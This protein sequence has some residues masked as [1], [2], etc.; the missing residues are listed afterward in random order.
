MPPTSGPVPPMCAAGQGW[1]LRSVLA[2]RCLLKSHRAW[3]RSRTTTGEQPGQPDG[4]G[5]LGIS[6]GP[7]GG[8]PPARASRM[9]RTSGI[10]EGRMTYRRMPSAAAPSRSLVAISSTVPIQAK[11]EWRRSST[12][13]P[14]DE[15]D[16]VP[17]R[18]SRIVGDDHHLHE[19]LEL[20]T[21]V[22]WPLADL[23]V[24]TVRRTRVGSSRPVTVR[25]SAEA[26][27]EAGDPDDVGL[28][29]PAKRSTRP[30][31]PPTRAARDPEPA[32][33]RSGR[34][35]RRESTRRSTRSSHR[36]AARS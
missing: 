35:R 3:R 4:L 15:A 29:R 5:K 20:W 33:G 25:P 17:R 2:L 28:S 22:L 26:C 21:P 24:S 31:L 7:R 12:V 34:H 1:R 8:H 14:S 11:G 27:S 19:R 36:R 13:A 18:A 30:P 23:T 6:T 10:A 16:Q 9:R 32:A